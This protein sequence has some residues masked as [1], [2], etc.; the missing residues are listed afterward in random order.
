MSLAAEAAIAAARKARDDAMARLD[1]SARAEV[2]RQL[3]DELIHTYAR[4]GR[5]FSANDIRPHIPDDVNKNV[6]GNRF[7]HAARTGVIRRIGLTPS[8]KRTTHLKDVGC[9]IGATP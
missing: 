8:S 4:A 3:V 2:D 7:T 1:S 9:W 5:P 6:I